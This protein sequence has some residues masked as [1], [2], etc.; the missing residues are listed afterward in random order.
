MEGSF[1]V[2]GALCVFQV[3]LRQNVIKPASIKCFQERTQRGYLS[4]VSCGTIG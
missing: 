2:D 3:E 1:W 4:C